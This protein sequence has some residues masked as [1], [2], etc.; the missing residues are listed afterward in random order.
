MRQEMERQG[1]LA[2]GEVFS[3]SS[4][5]ADA[6]GVF[7]SLTVIITLLAYTLLPPFWFANSAADELLGPK[8]KPL[9]SVQ[10]RATSSSDEQTRETGLR[11][12][13]TT[14]S[15][16]FFYDRE[17]TQTLVIPTAQIVGM[18]HDGPKGEAKEDQ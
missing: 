16:V 3:V 5:G 14:Q 10:Y 2:P 11:V 1:A 7:A 8:Y 12:I 18:E 13:G 9:T 17:D 15:F 4:R 6:L